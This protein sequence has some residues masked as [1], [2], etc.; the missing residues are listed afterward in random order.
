MKVNYQDKA[1]EVLFRA[2]E[3]ERAPERAAAFWNDYIAPDSLLDPLRGSAGFQR[4]ESVGA[5]FGDHQHAGVP[6]REFLR[7]PTQEC[8]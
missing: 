4:L 8:G 3:L 5:T 6:G 2:V 7:V 1:V